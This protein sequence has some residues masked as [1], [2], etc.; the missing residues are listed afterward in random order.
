LAMFP[1][2]DSAQVD[3]T[4]RSMIGWQWMMPV[5][6]RA[7]GG[8]TGSSSVYGRTVR[9]LLGPARQL[10]DAMDTCVKSSLHLLPGAVSGRD[11]AVARPA[12]L[13]GL[14]SP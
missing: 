9:D 13:V 4:G 5:W 6:A 1:L 12:R 2:L 7:E 10:C 3:W 8:L 11:G 14:D